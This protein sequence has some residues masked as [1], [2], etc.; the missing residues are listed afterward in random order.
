MGDVS[1]CEGRD[2]R[3]IYVWMRES[4]GF[5]RIYLTCFGVLEFECPHYGVHYTTLLLTT[6]GFEGFAVNL[7]IDFS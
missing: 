2:S 6:L 1:Y 7:P 4:V 3:V 5:W